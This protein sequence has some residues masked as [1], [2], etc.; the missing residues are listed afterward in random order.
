MQAELDAAIQIRR[1]LDWQ[2]SDDAD[3]I[4]GWALTQLLCHSLIWSRLVV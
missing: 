2:D 4:R 1:V 3:N